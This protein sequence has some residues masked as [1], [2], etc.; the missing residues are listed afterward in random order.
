M[1]HSLLGALCALLAGCA[2]VQG[3]CTYTRD[4]VAD[5]AASE[6]ITCSPGGAALVLGRWRPLLTIERPRN[7]KG[8]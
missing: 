3:P 7:E 8:P 1:R 5:E 4:F 2:S 6:T